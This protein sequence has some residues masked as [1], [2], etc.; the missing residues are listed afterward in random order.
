MRDWRHGPVVP[1]L[2]DRRS[3]ATG[4]TSSW[5]RTRLRVRGIRDVHD[6]DGRWPRLAD[7]LDGRGVPSLEDAMGELELAP[8]H[9]ALRAAGRATR[10]VRRPLLVGVAE[11]EP[12]TKLDAVAAVDRMLAGVPAE[13][14]GGRWIDEWLADRRCQRGPDCAAPASGRGRDGL[15][16]TCCATSGSAALIGVNEHEGVTSTSARKRFASRV[17]ALELRGGETTRVGGRPPRSPATASMAWP[18]SS[19]RQPRPTAARA[20]PIA[21]RATPPPASRRHCRPKAGS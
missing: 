8:L 6:T 20:S 15:R 9:A 3:R 7:W 19:H 4:C 16:P 10:S 1:A 12:V 13:A 21:K 17:K 14:R 11:A 18:P 2:A 5:A